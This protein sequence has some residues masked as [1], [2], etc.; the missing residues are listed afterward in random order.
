MDGWVRSDQDEKSFMDYFNSMSFNVALPYNDPKIQGL[1]TK[2]GI[3]GIPTLVVLD[4]N[5][6]V[7]KAIPL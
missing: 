2:W 7:T 4:K 5:G 1:M 6:N 3:R